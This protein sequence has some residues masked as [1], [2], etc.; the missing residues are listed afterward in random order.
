MSRQA[1][2]VAFAVIAACAVFVADLFAHSTNLSILYTVVVYVLATRLSERWAILSAVL[3]I[4]ATYGGLFL[5][6]RA[7]G[8]ED[9]A[10]LLRNYRMINR[11]FCVIAIL[12]TAGIAAWQRRWAK[13][14]AA[15]LDDDELFFAHSMYHDL[16]NQVKCVVSMAI[17]MVIAGALI[18]VDWTTSSEFNWPILY[19]VPLAQCV[20]SRS[21]P[22]ILL[23]TPLLLVLAWVGFWTCG[24]VSAAV[25][26]AHF[27]NRLIASAVILGL[28][29]FGIWQTRKRPD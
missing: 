27:V 13:D 6:P 28:A 24:D 25:P 19:A 2:E 10:A 17:A 16:V 20:M 23:T 12:A 21:R 11:S 29:G 9:S 14:M 22:A 26:V 8:L 18:A 1:S 3:L 4:A 15:D 7:P 5:G